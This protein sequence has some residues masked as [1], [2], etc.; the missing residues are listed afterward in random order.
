MFLVH[1][2][3]V[4]EIGTPGGCHEN[5]IPPQR[6][7]KYLELNPTD[8]KTERRSSG[9][10]V[11]IICYELKIDQWDKVNKKIHKLIPQKLSFALQHFHF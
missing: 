8:K 4:Q 5:N 1:L 9:E 2:V 6:L 11:N 3:H 10:V 7:N